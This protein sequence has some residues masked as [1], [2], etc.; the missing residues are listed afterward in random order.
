MRDEFKMRTAIPNRMKQTIA[1]I[2]SHKNQ[3]IK[4]KNIAI[5]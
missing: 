2:L 5:L 4:G 1:S 3:I